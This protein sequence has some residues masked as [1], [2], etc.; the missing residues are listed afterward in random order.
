MQMAARR[1]LL[2]VPL[3]AAA[4]LA[5]TIA[6]QVGNPARAAADITS[7]TTVSAG[8]NT[9]SQPLAAGSPSD[10]GSQLERC[11]TPRPTTRWPVRT[12]SCPNR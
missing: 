9:V 4:L 5:A 8:P 2:L 6:W 11:Y 10:Y 1:R 7:T 3:A 12:R